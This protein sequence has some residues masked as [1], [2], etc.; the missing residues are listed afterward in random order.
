M[1]ELT[2]VYCDW[3]E[4]LAPEVAKELAMLLMRLFPG[5]MLEPTLATSELTDGFVPR[6][7]RLG[8]RGG[9]PDV[10]AALTLAKLTDF[11]FEERGDPEQWAQNRARLDVLDEAREVLGDAMSSDVA[12]WVQQNRLRHPLRAKQWARAAEGWHELRAGPLS[13]DQIR[14]RL[15]EI[16]MGI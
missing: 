15:D 8:G 12:A 16:L 10:G 4:A 9:H 5:S 3:F 13:D 1:A 14:R 6:M 2:D 7:R 11:I